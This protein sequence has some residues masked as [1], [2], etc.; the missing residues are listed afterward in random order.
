VIIDCVL[1]HDVVHSVLIKT[2]ILTSIIYPMSGFGKP[3]LQ[4]HAQ[5]RRHPS[6]LLR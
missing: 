3:V 1:F 2:F 5:R 4:K 6:S